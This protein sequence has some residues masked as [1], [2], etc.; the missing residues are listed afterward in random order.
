MTKF[1]AINWNRIENKVDYSAWSR[2][3]DFLWEPERIPLFNDRKEFKQL[4]KNTQDIILHGFAALAF[5][6]SL[7]V[8]YGDDSLKKDAATPQEVSVLSALGYLEAI[9]NK[10]Y[11]NVIQNLAKPSEVNEYIDWANNRSDFQKIAEIYIDLYENGSWW[12]KKIAI[13]VMEMVIYHTC[14]FGI[15]KV[16]GKGKLVRTTEVVKYAIRTTTFN[17]MYP[18]VKFR[19]EAAKHSEKEQAEYE[20]WTRH[21]IDKITKILEES[22]NE[23]YG[24]IGWE[25]DALHYLHYSINKDLMNLGMDEMFDENVDQL[26]EDLSQGLIKSADFEDFFYYSNRHTLTHIDKI[27]G[28]EINNNI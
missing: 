14:Y 9:A 5:L 19:L 24:K 23:Q 8:R 10:S 21:F 18:G 26:S 15:L 16:F 4:D 12:Q 17:A 25:E 13:S 20:Q 7:Q 27:N 22:I 11:S 1:N 2:L 6:S 3:N 28:K